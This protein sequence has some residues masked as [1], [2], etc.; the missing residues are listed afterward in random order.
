MVGE[1]VCEHCGLS[2]CDRTCLRNV[3]RASEEPEIVV[4]QEFAERHAGHGLIVDSEGPMHVAKCVQCGES[5]EIG[6]VTD[7]VPP[8]E[9]P[10]PPSGPK[11]GRPKIAAD[12]PFRTKRRFFRLRDT[13]FAFLERIGEGNASKGLR[14]LVDQMENLLK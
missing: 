1:R 7:Y 8:P 10:R 4:P 14:K 5:V 6:P 9:P 11:P 2:T 3:H 13:D 12:S